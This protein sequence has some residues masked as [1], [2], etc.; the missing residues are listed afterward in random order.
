MTTQLSCWKQNASGVSILSRAPSLEGWNTGIMGI[1][2]GYFKK[3]LSFKL[4]S[5]EYEKKII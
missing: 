4:Q 1:F 2:K 3:P 5:T